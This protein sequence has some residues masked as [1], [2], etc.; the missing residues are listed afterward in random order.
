MTDTFE[1]MLNFPLQ[2][3][4][5]LVS[6]A[7]MTDTFERGAVLLASSSWMTDTFEHGAVMLASSA[8]IPR[9]TDTFERGAFMTEAFERTAA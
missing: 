9:M 5:L 3:A 7:W 8:W 1:P 6:G 4:V 2:L